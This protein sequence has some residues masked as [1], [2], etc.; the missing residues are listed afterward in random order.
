MAVEI[1]D[2][3][4]VYEE[5]EIETFNPTPPDLDAVDFSKVVVS[6][7]RDSDTF[8]VQLFGRGRDTVSVGGPKF[9]YALVDPDTNECV[10]FHVEHFLAHHV[11]LCPRL[12]DMLEDADLRGISRDEVRA[13]RHRLMSPRQRLES[14]LRRLSRGRPEARKRAVV[15]QFRDD[16]R[17]PLAWPFEA[18]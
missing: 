7:D 3:I 17:H 8:I 16:G 13:L 4:N 2:K 5:P 10:G 6:Y 18:V 15:A 9:L 11:R 1:V 14:R 12:L